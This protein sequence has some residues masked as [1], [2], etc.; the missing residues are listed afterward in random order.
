MLVNELY[1]NKIDDI[2]RGY[3]ELFRVENLKMMA[4][5]I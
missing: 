1:I 2:G 5:Y 4:Y 3:G